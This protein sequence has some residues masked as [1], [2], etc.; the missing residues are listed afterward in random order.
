MNGSSELAAAPG[1]RLRSG[2]RSLKRDG[3]S[4]VC[5]SQTADV[6]R[7]G[8]LY[9][10]GASKHAGPRPSESHSKTSCFGALVQIVNEQN[11]TKTLFLTFYKKIYYHKRL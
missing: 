11:G 2:Q 1:R 8:R 9:I 10:D 3:G 5:T 6:A 4:S 7:D